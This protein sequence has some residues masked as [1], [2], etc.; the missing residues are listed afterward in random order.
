MMIH[1]ITGRILGLRPANERRRYFVTTGV[2]LE[3]A[4]DYIGGRLIVPLLYN[5]S[6]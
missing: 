2:N 5:T 3:S 1:E 6:I 4:M